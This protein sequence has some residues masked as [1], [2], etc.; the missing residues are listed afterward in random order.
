[1]CCADNSARQERQKKQES[2]VCISHNKTCKIIYIYAYIYLHNIKNVF[3]IAKCL[4]NT[5]K[6]RHCFIL[7]RMSDKA[8]IK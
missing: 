3:I 2:V 8:K 5:T 4:I 1:M 6:T 7:M